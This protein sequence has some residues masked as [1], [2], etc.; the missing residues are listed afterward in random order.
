MV[1]AVAVLKGGP[2][3]TG[4]I[5]LSQENESASTVIKGTITGLK[6]GN[7]GFHIHEFG[8]NTNGCVSAGAHYNPHGKNHGAPDKDIRHTG[9]LGNVF[10]NDDGVAEFTKTDNQVKLIGPYSVIG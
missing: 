4:T 5:L 7:H 6:K 8:D 9:D 10:A 3:V 1:N 2:S